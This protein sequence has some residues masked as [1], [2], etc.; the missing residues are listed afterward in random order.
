M[1][2]N[3]F[4]DIKDTARRIMPSNGHVILFGSQARG[5]SRVNSDWDLLVLLDKKKIEVSDHDKYTYPFWELGWKVNAM[6]HP[7][8]Y[9]VDDW[10]SNKSLFHKNVEQDGIVVC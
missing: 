5:D 1:D 8:I 4:S 6:I 7:V 9:T 2:A 10:N 3:V